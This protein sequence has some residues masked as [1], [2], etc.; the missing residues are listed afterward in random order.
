MC[1]RRLCNFRGKTRRWK[2]VYEVRL[3]GVTLKD[4]N[5]VGKFLDGTSIAECADMKEILGTEEYIKCFSSAE[6][7]G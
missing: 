5:T 7:R 1:A 6:T 2:V 3:D 4:R